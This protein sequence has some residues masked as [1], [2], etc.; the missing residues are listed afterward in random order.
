VPNLRKTHE[1]MLLPLQNSVL[2]FELASSAGLAAA[3]I[4]MFWSVTPPRIKPF[5]INLTFGPQQLQRGYSQRQT[6]A[7]THR[8]LALIHLHILT[9]KP[10]VGL[11]EGEKECQCGGAT[12]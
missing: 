7:Q 5:Q 11:Y 6:K 4:H 1:F 9:G 10:A 12:R 8:N 2:L 3:Q